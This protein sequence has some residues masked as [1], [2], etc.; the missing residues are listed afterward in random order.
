ML[1]THVSVQ[2]LP[3]TSIKTDGAH[4]LGGLYTGREPLHHSV[5]T[6]HCLIG[7]QLKS[8]PFD[9]LSIIRMSLH[10]SLLS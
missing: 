3:S 4:A 2:I 1:K 6:L 5:R 7:L 8:L 9:Q 10:S